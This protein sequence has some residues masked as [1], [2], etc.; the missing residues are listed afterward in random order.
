[1]KLAIQKLGFKG[2]VPYNAPE[3][4]KT[5][6]VCY[7]NDTDRRVKLLEFLKENK[8]DVTTNVSIKIKLHEEMNEYQET[9][10]MNFKV[11]HHDGRYGFL[12]VR[13]TDNI[14]YIASAVYYEKEI[15]TSIPWYIKALGSDE[16]NWQEVCFN[17]QTD[18]NNRII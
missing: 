2:A 7:L 17:I 13:K 6:K 10:K 3:I 16:T 14:F 4:L 18:S 9:G 15:D 12:A 5:D 8:I 1:M 11:Y